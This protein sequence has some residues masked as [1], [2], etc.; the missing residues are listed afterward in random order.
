VILQG[1]D[2]G[3]WLVI[4]SMNAT[5]RNND[6]GPCN[7]YDGQDPGAGGQAYC[8]NGS[9]EYCEVTETFC[10]GYNEGHL[11][12][13]NLIHDFG[14]DDSFYNGVGSDDCHWECMY[15]SYA[16]RLTVRANVFRNCAN[17]GNIFNTYS[18][19]GGSFTAD[20]GYRDYTIEN[21][22]FEQPCTNSGPPCGGRHDGAS[23]I[24][25]CNIYGGTDLTNVKLRFNTFVGGSTFGLDNVC[26]Q[27][28]GNGLQIVGN[29]MKRTST[30]CGVGWTP[31]Y[32]VYNVYSGS[33][34]C[35]ANATNVG[36][37]L[38]TLIL[39][40][41]NGGDAHLRGSAGSTVADGYVPTSVRGGC[42]ATDIDGQPRPSSGSCDAGADER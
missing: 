41:T 9:I 10:A 29:L 22:V 5:V 39:S 20:F 12:E 1:A 16:S 25:H 18:N 23:G 17:G 38:S 26:S 27:A 15:V 35:G 34:T 28:A 3:G 36:A 8:D 7:S 11:V 37:D 31:E 42:P 21:N 4:D 2:F 24:G 40:D 13:G 14:C 6:I 33:G 32:V 19:G 30:T